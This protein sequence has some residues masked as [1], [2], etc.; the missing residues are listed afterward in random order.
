MVDVPNI[1]RNGVNSLDQNPSGGPKTPIRITA[2]I[3]T[4]TLP[5]KI[6][7]KLSE[8]PLSIAASRAEHG[9]YDSY[10]DIGMMYSRGDGV[11]R[12]LNHAVQYYIFGAQKGSTYSQALLGNAYA[13]GKGIQKDIEQ[14][15]YWYKQAARNGN[16]NAM[17]EL[18]YIY[19][20]GRLGVKKDPKEAQYWKDMAERAGKKQ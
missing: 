10:A 20:T 15:L 7:E 14:A 11:K 18:G 19:E 8:D 9:D 6:A 12:N 17:K 16:V 1:N 5:S 3:I 13:Y 2:T 4:V